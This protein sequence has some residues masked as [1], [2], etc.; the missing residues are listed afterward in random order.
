MAVL[1][2]CSFVALGEQH[3][4]RRTRKLKLAYLLQAIIRT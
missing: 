2:G 1:G 3:M 4:I